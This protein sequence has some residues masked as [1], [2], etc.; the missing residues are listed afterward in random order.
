MMATVMGWRVSNLETSQPDKGKPIM[1]LIGMNNSTV[2]NSAS[3]KLKFAF[4]VG[5]REVHV[6]KHTPD[7][8]K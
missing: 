8:K 6:E 3:L 7:K 5:M 4:M 1:E 2:P